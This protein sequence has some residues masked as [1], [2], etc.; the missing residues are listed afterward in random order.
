M[1]QIPV[2]RM[3]GDDVKFARPSTVVELA[4]LDIPADD[5]SPPFVELIDRVFEVRHC[6]M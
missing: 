5:V 2:L 6:R 4:Y 3:V 1:D